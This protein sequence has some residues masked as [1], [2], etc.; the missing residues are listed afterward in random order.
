MTLFAIADEENPDN[1]FENT[2]E[3]F[4]KGKYDRRTE[5]I[6]EEHQ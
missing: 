1:V 5:D 2:L 4:F 6:L 3:K